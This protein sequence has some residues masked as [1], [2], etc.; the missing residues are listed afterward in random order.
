VGYAP[1]IGGYAASPQDE[2]TTLKREAE[3][4]KQQLDAVNRRIEELE[5]KTSQA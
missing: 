4:I 5:G 3:Y 2:A 1:Y